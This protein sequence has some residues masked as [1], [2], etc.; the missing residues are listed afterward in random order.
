MDDEKLIALSREG[1]LEAFNQLVERYQSRVYR[2]A[3]RMVGPASA[4]DASQDA[5][6]S[7]FKSIRSFRGGNFRSWLL[8]ITANVCR[9]QLRAAKRK[10][11]ASL[12]S[13]LEAGVWEPTSPGRS[14]EEAASDAELNA[15][16]MTAVAAL[17]PDQRA[18][19]VL[20]DIE[21]Y[22]YEETAKAVG[23]S[24]GTVKSRLSRAREKVR[25]AFQASPELLPVQYRL[26][27]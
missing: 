27:E 3:Y 5:F 2:L 23:A 13:M 14:P 17:P 8:R 24:L 22:S 11:G 16:I 9:D 7:A 1:D 21:G 4:D 15:A 18:V 10:G 26:K 12:E 25:D 6:I 20:I 19:L